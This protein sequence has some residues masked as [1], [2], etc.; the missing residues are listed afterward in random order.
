MFS[1][2]FSGM[3]VYSFSSCSVPLVGQLT[4]HCFLLFFSC[5]LFSFSVPNVEWNHKGKR[6]RCTNTLLPP[7]G[8]ALSSQ[9]VRT[10]T[11]QVCICSSSP[12]CRQS[13]YVMQQ[14]W[15]PRVAVI[16]TLPSATLHVFWSQANSPNLGLLIQRQGYRRAVIRHHSYPGQA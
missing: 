7:E 3:N 15:T 10:V 6:W 2:V 5:W 14:P 4:I 12:S 16:F 9:P 8:S 1:T 13:L 11:R